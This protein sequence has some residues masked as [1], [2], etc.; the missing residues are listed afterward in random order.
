MYERDDAA[1]LCTKFQ[2]TIDSRKSGKEN[3]TR[4]LNDSDIGY[5]VSQKQNQQKLVKNKSFANQIKKSKSKQRLTRD[6]E[7]QMKRQQQQ[8]YK[9][10]YSHEFLKIILDFQLQEHERFLYEFNL[11]FK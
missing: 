2:E 11:L 1:Y 4:G 10:V 6:E 8:E 9:L 5:F 3:E 7:I